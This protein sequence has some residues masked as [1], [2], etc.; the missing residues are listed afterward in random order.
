MCRF[1]FDTGPVA[2]ESGVDLTRHWIDKCQIKVFHLGH[3]LKLIKQRLKI[4]YAGQ[5]IE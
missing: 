2:A 4:Y 3:E 1:E 5:P